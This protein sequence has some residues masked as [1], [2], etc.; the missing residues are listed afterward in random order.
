MELTGIYIYFGLMIVLGLLGLIGIL[1]KI[2]KQGEKDL[3]EK[4]YK[5]GDINNSVYKKYLKL[6]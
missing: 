5:N 2:S 1:M 4:M 6:T 3:L